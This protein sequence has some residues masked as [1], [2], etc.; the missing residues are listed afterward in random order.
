MSNIKKHRNNE[1][2]VLFDMEVEYKGFILS[3][4]VKANYWMNSE[5]GQFNDVEVVA[6][7]DKTMANIL[8]KLPEDIH[9]EILSQAQYEVDMLE[10]MERYI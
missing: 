6:V 2:Q 7:F 8:S 1:G 10:S 5:A 3:V 4:E 9:G